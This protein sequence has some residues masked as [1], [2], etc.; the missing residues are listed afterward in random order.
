M[1]KVYVIMGVS[2]CG[3][4]TVG[5]AL[6][7]RLGCPFYDGDDFHP[8]AN[9]AKMAG[10][11]PLNDEDRAPW[12][13]VLHDLLARHVEKGETAVLACSALKK[14]YRDQLRAGQQDNVAFVYLQGSFDLIWQRMAARP[15]HYMK[16]AML[17]SQFDT[18]EEPDDKEAFRINISESINAIV[19]TIFA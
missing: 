8:A 13:A 3:K 17:Q 9:V 11:A 14:A 7:V 19:E 5:Q 12:L 4:S 18:L 15:N 6:A 10:G 16:A 1:T 2:G